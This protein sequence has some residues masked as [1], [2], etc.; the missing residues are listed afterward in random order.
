METFLR[1]LSHRGTRDWDILEAIIARRV[2]LPDAF[3]HW[4]AHTL[5]ELRKELNDVDLAPLL[6]EWE[7]ET[8]RTLAAE[9]F[10]KYLQEVRLL[11]PADPKRVRGTK[12]WVYR[13]VWRSTVTSGW[14]KAALGTVPGSNTNRRRHAAAWINAFEYLVERGTFEV[15]PMRGIT[16]PPPNRIDRRRIDRFRDVLRYVDAMPEGVHRAMA[17]LREGAGL[18][19]EAILALRVSDVVDVEHRIIWAHGDKNEHR[20]RQVT[21][22]RWAW[23]RFYRYV[24]DG[25]FHADAKLFSTS[26]SRHWIKHNET[27]ADLRDR[28][29]DIPV[30][31]TLHN[32]RN[33]YAVRSIRRGVPEWAIANNLGHGDTTTVRRL[34]GKFRPRALDLVQLQQRRCKTSS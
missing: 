17:A 28:G 13:T 31:Y 6:A 32:A 3:D 22:E 15:N 9:T 33:S 1:A 19:M 12:A 8:K 25:L 30:G 5:D 23:K 16:L 26:H 4:R 27:C 20:D 2:E 11:F 29:F 34:Y 7:T 21:V 10:R 24:V 18:E 14:L